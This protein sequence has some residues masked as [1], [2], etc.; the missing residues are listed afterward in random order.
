M[1][2][3]ILPEAP[4]YNQNS[5]ANFYFLGGINTIYKFSKQEPRHWS[6]IPFETGSVF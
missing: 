4:G 3:K 1:P 6:K 2:E 5:H